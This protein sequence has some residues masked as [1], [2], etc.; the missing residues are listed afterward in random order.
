VATDDEAASSSGENLAEMLAHIKIHY[1]EAN[2]ALQLWLANSS[3]PIK[4]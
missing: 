4:S 2:A 1:V 3:V